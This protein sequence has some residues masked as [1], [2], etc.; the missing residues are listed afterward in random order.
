MNPRLIGSLLCALLLSTTTLSAA[1]PM[2]D[3]TDLFVAG[4]GGYELYRIPGIV[5]TKSGAILAYCE[6]RKSTR[7]DW[8][9]IDVVM[10]RS[11]DGGKTW[12]PRQTVVDVQGELPMNPVAVAQNLDNPG[13][14]TVNNPVAIVD[15]ESGVVHFLYCLEYMRCFYMRSEDD[16]ETWSEAVEITDAFEAFR[17]DYDWKVL[18][19]GPAH[20]IQLQRGENKGRLVVPVWLSLGTGGHAHRPSVTSTIYSDDQGKTWQRGEIA[21]PDTEDF[22]YPNETVV[23]ELADGTV[24]LNTRTESKHH[25]RVVTTSPNGATDWSEP[26]FDDALLEPICMAGIT[27]VRDPQDGKPGLIAFSNPH[28]LSRLDGKRVEGKSRDRRNLSIKLSEDEGQTWIANRPLQAGYSA[29]SDMAALE[30]GTMLCLYERGRD[31]DMPTKRSTSYTHLT[32][33]RFNEAW[34]RGGSEADICIYGGTSGGVAAAVQA[35][36]MGKRVILM[37]PGG[38]LGGMTSGGLSAVDIGDPRSV[39]GIAR[40]YFTRLVAS[41][42]KELN[43]GEAFNKHGKG[44]PATGGAY[45]IEPHIAEEVFDEMAAEIGVIVMRDVRLAE[46]VKDG[47]RITELVTEDGRRVRAGMFIDTT[48]EGDLMAQTGVSYTL[49]REGNAKYGEL[50]NGIYYSAKYQPRTGHGEPQENGRV[51]GGQGAWDRD[52]PLDPY[53]VKGD[54]SSGLLPLVN[55]GEPGIPGEPAPGIQAYCFRLCLTTDKA[56]QIPITAPENYDPKRYELVVRF[57]EACLENG[58]DMDLRWFSKHD[59][60]PNDKWDFNTATFGGNLPGANWGWPEASYAEREVLSKEIENYHRGLLHFLATDPRVPE[61]VRNDMQ[62]FGLPKDEFPDTGGWPHQIYVREGRRMVSDFVMTEHHT[63][64]RETPERSIGLGSYG[65][66]AHEIRRIVKDGVVT[67]EGKIATGR[68]GFGPY[69]IDYGAIVPRQDECENLLVTFALSASHTA[70]ASIRME[71]V[72]MITSQSAATAASLALDAEVPV[73][74]VDYEALRKRLEAEGQVLTWEHAPKTTHRPIT[75]PASLPGIVL[76]DDEAEYVGN[77]QL[78]NASHA[79]VG[80]AYR[81]DGNENRG[82]KS[83]TFTTQVPESGDYQVRLYFTSHTNRSTKTKV[84]LNQGDLEETFYVNQRNP[85]LVDDLPKPLGTF[86]LTAGKDFRLSVFNEGA[87]GIVN[88]DALQLLPVTPKASPKPKTLSLEAIGKK[89]FDLCVIEAT[90]G[91]VGCAVRAAREGLSVLLVNRTPHLGGI[92]SSGLGVWDTIWEGKR[93]P[94]YDELRQAIF[95]HYKNTYSE[96]SSQYRHA[97]PGK[98]GHTNG[99]FEPHVVEALITEMVAREPNITLL[100]S[101][102]PSDATRKGRH[103]KSVTLQEFQG[104]KSVKVQAQAFADCTYEGDLLPLAKVEYRVGREARDEFKESHAG[105]IYMK[106]TRERPAAI[107]EAQHKAHENLGMR[108]FGGFQEVLLPEST[109]AS[110][111]NVQAFNYRTILTSD[112]ENRLP[113]PKPANYDPAF[114]KTLEFTSIVRPIPNDK[115]GWNRPQILGLHQDY[116]EGDWETRQAVMD[117]HWEAAMALLYFLQHDPSVPGEKREHWLRYG[118]AKDEFPD[119]GHRPYEIYVREA[120]RLVGRY[121]LTQNDLMPA[122]G[123]IR[124]PSHADAIAMTDWYMDSHAVTKGGVRGSLDE[125]KMMLHAETWIGQ[126]PYRC[127]LP[128]DLDNLVV[129]VCFS[130]THVAWG[131]IRL[132]PTWMQ[133][134]EAAAYALA[135]AKNRETTAGQLPADPLVRELLQERFL[136]SYFS[137]IQESYQDPAAQYFATHGFFDSYEAELNAP[138]DAETAGAWAKGFAKLSLELAPTAEQL[139]GRKRGK[140]LGQVWSQL[141]R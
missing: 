46:V 2:L 31:A 17:P 5:V 25:R 60:L 69:R 99:K 35:A 22:V 73:Q 111:T 76:D 132:E 124:P 131:A 126:I 14:N 110:D 92:L 97:L 85:K 55:E 86:T 65:T 50:Y 51:R 11:L 121:V 53:V 137:D 127:L 100:T 105:V 54:P 116:V 62:R 36:R 123:Q 94:I 29:Y 102:I 3:K 79:F 43:W 10:R 82:G 57:I 20:G 135:L 56:N 81:H 67:R 113:V 38:H 72:F 48:Y 26:R 21:V 13:E 30:D 32:V 84:T 108:K 120:R 112:P 118:L 63:F 117:A 16:G 12:L 78:S 119:N 39:G 19:T 44:G 33:A 28:N 75:P 37:E 140:V 93:S 6:A 71:P 128:Q 141:N 136:I 40:E 1:E 64:G 106:S 80:V 88:V 95:D 23:V 89:E 90:P 58:D 83:A 9:K 114:L 42:R 101:Y 24:M 61:K 122:K 68:G 49:Q 66:D 74:D 130:A 45:S 138:V 104:E 91:G 8:G 134:G 52:F 34:V 133:T 87:D 115:I 125:G 103:L 70:F 41:Y 47:A 98:S 27:R 109:G 107:S 4:E 77:W 129:P 18:A 15:Q 96:D 7:G 59:P 139:E